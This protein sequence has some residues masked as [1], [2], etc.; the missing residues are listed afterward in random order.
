MKLI[1]SITVGSGGTA[2]ISFN[3]IPQTYTDLLIVLAG[4]SDAANP[5]VGVKFNGSSSSDYSR[6]WLYGDGS[7]RDTGS[8]T[9]VSSSTAAMLIARSDATSNTFGNSQMY[10][11]NYAITAAKNG[12]GENANENN[13]TSAFASLTAMSR[14]T[15]DAVTSITFTPGS[16]N[17]AQYSSAYLYGIT[18]GSGGATAS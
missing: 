14:T 2:T 1:S 7:S 15:T 11:P 17:F 3:S 4:R 9:G 6:L 10:I 13:A 18:K 5:Y 16:G 12:S 8:V